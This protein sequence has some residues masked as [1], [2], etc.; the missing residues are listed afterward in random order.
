VK[1]LTE[2]QAEILTFIRQHIDALGYA[3]SLRDVSQQFALN[4]NGVRDHL[5]A[6]K[7]KGAISR[8]N[9]KARAIMVNPDFAVS[10]IESTSVRL[11][12]HE[13]RKQLSE[14][15]ASL[16]DDELESLASSEAAIRVEIRRRLA[17]ENKIKRLI[18][19]QLRQQLRQF[20]GSKNKGSPEMRELIGCSVS[21]LKKH[22]EAKWKLGMSWDN[23]GQWHI[24]H[25][26][27]CAAFDLTN[28]D[29]RKRCFH[30]SNLQPLWAAE[31][32]AK[33]DKRPLE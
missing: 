22:L 27:P 20:L 31:N 4:I 9:G 7:K 1:E 30:W 16:S 13:S 19:N 2:R 29:D 6:L 17:R 3:P 25:I 14:W 33:S 15:A 18:A 26:V 12:R 5:L 21:E 32:F 23:Y 24:D 28:E 8:A 11:I 10:T